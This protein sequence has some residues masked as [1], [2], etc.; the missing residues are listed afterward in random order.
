ML[1]IAANQ[2]ARVMTVLSV[3]EWI[4]HIICLTACV[5]LTIIHVIER[6]MGIV[7]VIDDQ[8]TT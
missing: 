6:G 5:S 7:G 3:V 2:S 4:S 1:V 8:C